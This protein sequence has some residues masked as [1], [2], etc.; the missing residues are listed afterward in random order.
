MK[1]DKV[2]FLNGA[3]EHGHYTKYE[4]AQRIPF[5]LVQVEQNSAIAKAL[6]LQNQ[7]SVAPSLSH[8]VV[9]NHDF[10]EYRWLFAPL[11]HL[12]DDADVGHIADEVLW[13]SVAKQSHQQILRGE[14]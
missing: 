6:H 3:S 10:L 4:H 13:I 5:V 1:G 9:V 2:R 14:Q 11:D 7:S 12:L 8:H